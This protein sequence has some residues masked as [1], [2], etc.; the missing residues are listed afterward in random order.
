MLVVKLEGFQFYLTKTA[1]KATSNATFCMKKV[2]LDELYLIRKITSNTTF[3]LYFLKESMLAHFQSL[4]GRS[5]CDA[6]RENEG[7][8]HEGACVKKSYFM[9]LQVV[10]SPLLRINFFTDNFHE[11]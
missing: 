7:K 1:L 8:I 4:S 9:N 5:N 11:V 10:I 2:C 6:F 3:R